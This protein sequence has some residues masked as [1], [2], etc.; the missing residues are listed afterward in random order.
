MSDRGRFIALTEEGKKFG[1]WLVAN[2]GKADFFNTP[3]GGW[4]KAKSGGSAEKW[5]KEQAE[6]DAL[7]ETRGQE[8]FGYSSD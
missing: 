8:K 7:R 5:A 6:Q 3:F 4:G 2:H 1:E